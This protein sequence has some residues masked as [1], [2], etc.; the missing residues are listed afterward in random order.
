VV[1]ECLYNL[2]FNRSLDDNCTIGGL[3]I[4]LG[5]RLARLY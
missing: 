5:L 2:L 3:Q 1:D 4:G